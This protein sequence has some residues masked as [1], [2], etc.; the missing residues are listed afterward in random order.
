MKCFRKTKNQKLLF[1]YLGFTLI[2]SNGWFILIGCLLVYYLYNKFKDR[3]SFES[4]SQSSH[5][6]GKKLL[7]TINDSELCYKFLNEF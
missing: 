3:F 1:L 5:K 6:P 2:Q 7:L 4:I